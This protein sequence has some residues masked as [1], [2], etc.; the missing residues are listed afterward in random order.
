MFDVPA[1]G[2]VTDFQAASSHK[3]LHYLPIKT[4]PPL[5]TVHL[6][7]FLRSLTP[8]SSSR[9]SLFRPHLAS[10]LTF[11]FP[12][13]LPPPSSSLADATP[14]AA[15]PH[16]FSFP[17]TPTSRNPG[18]FLSHLDNE[19]STPV[20]EERDA[21]RHAALELL[22]SLSEARPPMVKECAGWVSGVVRCCL[23]GMA[24]IRDN[25]FGQGWADA[26]DVSGDRSSLCTSIFVDMAITLE[27]R[28][29]KTM[30]LAILISL[31]KV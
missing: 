16:T 23:E 31:R 8:L 7:N 19:T 26:D 20:D 27:S 13:L 9:P 29:T 4:L 11:L 25:H 2:G 6:P 21:V 10:L 12:L 14:T 17:P 30:T 28:T 1:T 15:H 5:A 18:Y 22:V 24:E 3:Y